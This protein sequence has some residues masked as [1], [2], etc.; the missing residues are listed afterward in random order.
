VAL[1]EGCK[2]VPVATEIGVAEIKTLVVID[3][4]GVGV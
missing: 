3:D 2:F 1:V 4:E